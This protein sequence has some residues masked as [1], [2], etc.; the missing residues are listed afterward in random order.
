MPNAGFFEDAVFEDPSLLSPSQNL[1]STE[2]ARETSIDQQNN[3]KTNEGEEL[4]DVNELQADSSPALTTLNDDENDTANEITVGVADLKLPD[5][6][7]AN[8]PN[9]Q[10]NLSAADID[11]LL[12]KCLLQALHT[13]VKDKDL[14]MPGSTLWWD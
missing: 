13:T 9:D 4:L 12:D 11:L 8:D 6:G 1:D 14:P 5:T 10:H 7:S 3:A 2:V